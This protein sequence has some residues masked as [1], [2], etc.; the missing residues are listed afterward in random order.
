MSP[1]TPLPLA[2]AQPIIDIDAEDNDEGEEEVEDDDAE[3]PPPPAVV[4]FMSMWKALNGKEVLPGTRSAMLD[5]NIL[6]LTAIEAWR[7]KLLRDL[8]PRRFRVQQL[9]AIASY[10]NARACDFCQ[11]Q[12]NNYEDL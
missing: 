5:Q 9:E 4:R 7:E 6:Y 10:E 11:Q 8:L 2:S 12:I 3:E 1:F